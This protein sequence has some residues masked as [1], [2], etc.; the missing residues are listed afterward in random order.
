[1]QN[2]TDN[3]ID[4]LPNMISLAK[5]KQTRITEF[6]PFI[7]QHPVA[8]ADYASSC[9]H[10]IWPEAEDVISTDP[11]A[12]DKYAERVVKGRWE[13]GEPI[14]ATDPTVALHYAT[15]LGTPFPLGEEAIASRADTAF[16][17]AQ[18]VLKKR[19]ILGEAAIART[20]TAGGDNGW[21][22]RYYDYMIKSPADWH[23]WTEDQLKVSPCWMYLYAK[24]Y[25]KGRL[26]EILHNHMLT[27]GITLKDNYY[28]KKYFKAKRYQ[29]K[30]KYRRKKKFSSIVEEVESA[31]PPSI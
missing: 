12:S 29:K 22:K 20:E 6:E 1:M 25:M 3:W 9:I 14:I 15:R 23:D 5:R 11:N 16:A 21:V 17:Y 10:G 19:F 18:R 30:V 7:V 13:K 27:F 4:L 24:D 8:A 2:L 28:V 31:I 26:P